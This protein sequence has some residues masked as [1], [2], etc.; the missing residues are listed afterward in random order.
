VEV[1]AV[2]EESHR[3]GFAYRTLSGHPVNG[4][5]AFK[6]T[7]TVTRSVS[8]FVRSPGL[9]PSG[10]GGFSTRCFESRSESPVD[11]IYAR[12]ADQI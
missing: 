4:E 5:E 12:S 2:V 3:V 11:D 8:R 9:H 1:V 6:C 10:P 7:V